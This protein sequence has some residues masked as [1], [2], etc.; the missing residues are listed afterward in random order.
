MLIQ[1]NQKESRTEKRGR[2]A[3]A[4]QSGEEGASLKEERVSGFR[5]LGSSS[6]T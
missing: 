1:G 4:L 2:K 6:V 5:T 3:A